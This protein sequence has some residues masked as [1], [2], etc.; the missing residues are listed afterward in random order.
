MVVSFVKLIFPIFWTY[1]ISTYSLLLSV[2]HFRS[3]GSVYPLHVSKPSSTFILS[4][5]ALVSCFHPLCFWKDLNNL[6][7][8]HICC[9]IFNPDSKV[10]GT[11]MGPIWG[12]QDPGGPDVGPMNFAIWEIMQVVKTRVKK[13][14]WHYAQRR[15]SSDYLLMHGVRASVGLLLICRV[16][17]AHH[18]KG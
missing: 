11:N 18:I 9:L 15:Y 13:E 1:S 10:H 5:V 7:T 6:L 3:G 2:Y 16:F 12:R 14:M 4:Q 8:F 17:C